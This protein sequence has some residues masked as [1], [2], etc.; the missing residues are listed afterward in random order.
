MRTPTAS[1]ILAAVTMFSP[2][3]T[4]SA[5]ELSELKAQLK[6]MQ[7]Q[8]ALMQKR[9]EA[10][11]AEKKAETEAGNRLEVG[12]SKGAY[13]KAQDDSYAL[14]FR[15][16]LQPQYEYVDADGAENSGTF[17]IKR[18]QLR[19]FGNVLDPRL[20]Y[21]MMIQGRTT[22]AGGDHLDL[23]DLWVDWQWTETLQV[24]MGQ[25][26]VYYDHEDLQPSWALPLV[27]RSIINATLGFERDIGIRLHGKLLT[28]RLDYQ[29]YMING[30][31]RNTVNANDTF[32]YGS[33]LDWHILGTQQF[34][35]PDLKTSDTP[36]LALG[37]AFL[38]DNGNASLNNDQLNRF[39]TDL[40]FRYKGFSALTLVNLAHNEDRGATDYGLLA[41]GGYFAV[42][43]RLEIAARWAKIL[44]DGALGADTVDPAELTLG[45]NYY[46]GG[47]TAKLQL[48]YSRLWNNASTQDRD[49]NRVR[50]QW[51]LF[52]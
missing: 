36:H 23:R 26:F 6:A 37:A 34:L 51:Q 41:Q 8:M 15:F 11:E 46:I 42:P 30:D 48:D 31:G 49:D 5:E 25:F 24:M 35:V 43:E 9:I 2:A 38:H 50:L 40:T 14:H 32:V 29:L 19:L 13:I 44:K 12:Y 1:L 16:L 18:A 22:P 39:T 3:R 4:C 17:S 21:K 47:H 27:D 33:R 20:K 28:D 10:L 45:L 52:F 7:E